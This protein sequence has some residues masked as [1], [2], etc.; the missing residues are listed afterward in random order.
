MTDYKF[1]K[2]TRMQVRWKIANI[3]KFALEKLPLLESPTFQII[4]KNHQNHEATTQWKLEA[5]PNRSSL[6][7]YLKKVDKYT[8]P[9]YSHY[10]SLVVNYEMKLKTRYGEYAKSSKGNIKGIFYENRLGKITSIADLNKSN[11]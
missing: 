4:I 11:R 1:P 10:G 5:Q 2:Y 9:L 6:S 3:S 7:L 8:N